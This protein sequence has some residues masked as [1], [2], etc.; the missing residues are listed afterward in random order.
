MSVQTFIP[1]GIDPNAANWAVA[2]RVAGAFAPHEQPFPD[3]TL[4]LDPGNLLRGSTLTEVRAQTAGPF[5]ATPSQRVDRVVVDRVS[6]A[7]SVVTGTDGSVTPPAIPAGTLPVA[8]VHLL[9][10][11]D[12]VTNAI[13]VDERALA[14]LTPAGQQVVCRATLGGTN[15]TGVPSGAF[16]KVNFNTVDYNVGGGFD[17]ANKWFKP[18][19]PGYY[20]VQ[21]RFVMTVD[22]NKGLAAVLFKNG[23][24]ISNDDRYNPTNNSVSVSVSDL[25][26]LN[27][28]SD[29]VEVYCWHN[30]AAPGTINGLPV[31]TYFTAARIG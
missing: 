24:H 2:R 11:T 27:G 14:D 17:T 30:N 25:V 9:N 28:T 19:I 29:Y 3:M 23:S 22:A 16:T 26:H 5:A 7:A 31:S 8:R 12:A 10:T 15:Q 1:A 6:G 13:V 20:M 4:A 21:G 18:S